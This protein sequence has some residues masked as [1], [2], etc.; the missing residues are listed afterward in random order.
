MTDDLDC[1]VRHTLTD[2]RYRRAAL[3][4]GRSCVSAALDPA[5]PGV[6]DKAVWTCDR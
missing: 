5:L 4:D 3:A 2:G 6:E 1:V